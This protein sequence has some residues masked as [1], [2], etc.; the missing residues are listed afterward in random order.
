MNQNQTTCAN[1]EQPDT[2]LILIRSPEYSISYH[3][4]VLLTTNDPTSTTKDDDLVLNTG[5]I[6]SIE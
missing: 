2:M 4:T 1:D 6:S 3:E 5:E